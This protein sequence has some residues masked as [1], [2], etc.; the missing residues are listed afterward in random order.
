MIP[1][2]D[3]T[4]LMV[5]YG[6]LATLECKERLEND[7]LKRLFE[8]EERRMILTLAKEV[9]GNTPKENSQINDHYKLVVY[10]LQKMAFTTAPELKETVRLEPKMTAY[11]ML[12]DVTDIT[13]IK[14]FNDLKNGI[15]ADVDAYGLAVNIHIWSC[16]QV[17]T[18]FRNSIYALPKHFSEIAIA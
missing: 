1:I 5:V 15:I 4:T 11:Q 9:L 6:L 7:D 8:I 14:L 17:W 12:C 18:A 3:N 16:L 2:K 10:L 13:Q